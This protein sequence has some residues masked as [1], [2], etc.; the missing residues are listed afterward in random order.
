MKVSNVHPK[1]VRTEG[2]DYFFAQFPVSHFLIP[3]YILY[4]VYALT[5]AF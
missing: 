1:D 4:L 5:L 2:P 3:D